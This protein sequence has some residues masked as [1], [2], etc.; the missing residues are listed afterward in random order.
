MAA[1]LAAMYGT[2]PTPA[3][4]WAHGWEACHICFACNK[5]T[6]LPHATNGCG[7]HKVNY[8]ADIG[9]ALAP[10]DKPE[11]FDICELMVC[12]VNGCPVLSDDFSFDPKLPIFT[13]GSATNVG[14]PA[15]AVSAGAVFQIGD[16]GQHRVV[17]CQVPRAFPQSAVAAEH[18]A[19]HLV[20]RFVRPSEAGPTATVISDCQAVVSAFA[21]PHLHHGYRAKYG[22]LWREPGLLAIKDVLKTPAHRTREEAIAQNDE[23]NWFGNDKA[24]YWAKFALAATGKAGV[25]Y[26]E[27]RKLRLAAIGIASNKL[28]EHLQTEAITRLPRVKNG[29]RGP[30]Q[31][32]RCLLYTSDAGDAPRCVVLCRPPIL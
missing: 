6:D 20:F 14:I 3:W 28:A 22:G 7:A 12:T 11:V 17:R 5:P 9:R 24:D 1:C 18:I 4:L 21:H 27:D 15:L 32:R 31:A 26:K 10:T 25:L 29:P 19:I 8:L 13:D 16:N 2:F 23:A 30:R